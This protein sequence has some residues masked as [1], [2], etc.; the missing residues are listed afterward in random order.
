VTS[1][2][3]P[4]SSSFLSIFVKLLEAYQRQ[5]GTK[6]LIVIKMTAEKTD[7]Q[8]LEALLH[9]ATNERQRKMYQA[10]L[11]KA[12]ASS[13]PSDR[14]PRSSA[15][16]SESFRA[17]PGF[18]NQGT[19]DSVSTKKSV[20]SNVSAVESPSVKGKTVSTKKTTTKNKK[21]SSASSLVPVT[22]I[23]LT[24]QHTEETKKGVQAKAKG[25]SK[26]KNCRDNN[27]DKTNTTKT[28]QNSKNSVS[29][30]SA[31]SSTEQAIFQAVGVLKGIP[32]LEN[33]ELFVKI[34]EQKYKIEKKVEASRRQ[35]NLLKS[36]LEQNGSKEMLLRVYP[37]VSYDQDQRTPHHLFRLIRSYVYEEQHDQYSEGFTIRGIWRCVPHGNTTVI[38]IHRNIDRL[39]AFK[40][41]P[42]NI[43]KPYVKAQ[44]LPVVWDA[45]VEP[46]VY[47]PERADSE[48]MPC[49]FV[50]VRAAFKD[51][52]YIV[53]EMLEEP[54]L[55]IPTYIQRQRPL[56]NRKPRQQPAKSISESNE[57]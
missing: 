48:Q 9:S 20:T 1:S 51:G 41:L 56:K 26:K 13:V 53:E 22:E 57:P 15:M 42:R 24:K 31:S 35:I 38:T 19:D 3:L 14:I 8:K 40:Q 30:P 10:L 29:A 36:K 6:K 27:I 34:D 55:N 32:C 16:R 28:H 43:K 44:D 17:S 39:E 11:T 5:P 50:Q 45:P 54:T 33:G 4:I 23:N 37:N 46:F 7:L 2:L 25:Q 12:R 47:H 49:Y 18:S 21:T 52:L